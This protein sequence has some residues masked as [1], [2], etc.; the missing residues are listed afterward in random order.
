MGAKMSS[1][2]KKPVLCFGLTPVLQRTLVFDKLVLDDVN[3]ARKAIE[4]AAGKAINTA[5]ALVTLGTDA[6]VAGFNG[7]ESGRKVSAFIRS[8]GVKNRLTAMRKPTR[9]CTTLLSDADNKA[10][11]LVEEAPDPGRTSCKLFRT[12]NLKNIAKS[13][14]LA[15]SGTLPPFADDD[16]YVEFAREAHR[17]GVPLMIDSHRTALINVVFERPLLAKLNAYELSVTLGEPMNTER[18]I[19]QGMRDL[20]VMGAQNVLVTQGRGQAYLRNNRGVWRFTPPPVEHRVS[21]IGSGDCMLAGIIHAY[22]S[23]KGLLVAVRYG[24]ACGSA[25]VESVIPADIDRKRVQALFRLAKAE[26]VTAV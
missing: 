5:R 24:M 25:N 14:L 6:C 4:S 23:G 26:K 17:V 9:I 20:L 8:Y 3:R 12:E 1:Q 19:L 11:E 7:G 22:L 2:I 15:I 10:T 18:R 21:A 13:S 16:F